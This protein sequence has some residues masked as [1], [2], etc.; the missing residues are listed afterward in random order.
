MPHA[1][2]SDIVRCRDLQGSG[3]EIE[4]F[5][6]PER[7][8]VNIKQVEKVRRVVKL[9][10]DYGAR[11]NL[12]RLIV[13]QGSGRQPICGLQDRMLRG[14]DG[15]PELNSALSMGAWR[16]TTSSCTLYNAVFTGV[17]YSVLPDERRI[18]QK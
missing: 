3:T 7:Q 4:R 11:R 16:S 12:G 14:T 5:I 1:L 17:W 2:G 8:P 15:S 9:L 6:H 18:W 10:N 13:V